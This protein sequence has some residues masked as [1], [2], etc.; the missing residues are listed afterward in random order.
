[1]KHSGGRIYGELGH[2][3]TGTCQQIWE[4]SEKS[5][6][7]RGKLENAIAAFKSAKFSDEVLQ[8]M[9]FLV[10]SGPGSYRFSQEKEDLDCLFGKAA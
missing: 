3:D 7:I 2:P 5:E 4:N 1:M 9:F 6:T 8:G 10:F